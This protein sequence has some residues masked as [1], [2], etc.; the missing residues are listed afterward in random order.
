MGGE[1]SYIPCPM[2][3]EVLY[4][5]CAME[6]KYLGKHCTIHAPWGNITYENIVQ[7]MGHGGNITQEGI[8]QS[9]PHEWETLYNPWGMGNLSP[10]KTLYNPCPMSRKSVVQ[11][12]GHGVVQLLYGPWV[13]GP[14]HIV[15]PMTHGKKVAEWALFS[16]LLGSLHPQVGIV[17]VPLKIRNLKSDASAR[18][19]TDSLEG[20]CTLV[21]KDLRVSSVEAIQS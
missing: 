21:F 2:G 14:R 12:T 16:P 8:V 7:P 5:P 13:M 20:T 9:M 17:Q 10:G 15:W 11:P 3:G 4:N 1:A 6:K 19:K 18:V